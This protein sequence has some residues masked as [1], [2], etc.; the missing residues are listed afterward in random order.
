MDWK[1]SC[2][3]VLYLL[4]DEYTEPN[5]VAG[6]EHISVSSP[7]LVFT[8]F[9]SG[10][11]SV[12]LKCLSL[13]YLLSW[14]L[15]HCRVLAVLCYISNCLQHP[16]ACNV[17]TLSKR[18]L[19]LE[20]VSEWLRFNARLLTATILIDLTL[21][22][23]RLDDG[24]QQHGKRPPRVPDIRGEPCRESPPPHSCTGYPGER[25]SGAWARPDLFAAG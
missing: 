3:G 15:L 5:L 11:K 6:Y 1:C 24:Y 10:R 16:Q 22:R 12:L 2:P 7:T 18:S 13:S 9:S 23:Q 25:C 20:S 14:Y 8:I 17:S 4:I 21:L 19:C